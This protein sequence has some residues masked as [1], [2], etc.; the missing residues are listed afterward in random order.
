MSGQGAKDGLQPQDLVITILG[1]H[2]RRPGERVW[3]GGM[4]DLL[5]EFGFS[6]EAARAALSRLVARGLLLRH[7]QGRLVHYALTARAQELLAERDRRIFSFGRSAP[8]ADAWTVVW[9]AI[10]EDRRV[11]RSGLASRLRLLGFGSVQDATWIAASDREREVRE[12]LDR[13]R[14]TEFTSIFVGRIARGGEQALLLSGAWDLDAVADRYEDFLAEYGPYATVRGASALEPREAFVLRTSMLH[15]FRGFPFLDPELPDAILPIAG[16]RSKVVS[17]FDAV[18]DRLAAPAEEHFAAVAL[19]EAEAA[20]T[21]A[22]VVPA[23]A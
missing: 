22:P 4:V 5:G 15:A 8:A 1:A 19:V 17:T 12:I 20:A 21:A 13:L 23:R 16:R 2:V 6:I 11:E 3:S 10:P 7:R 18:Y 9:H 14:V